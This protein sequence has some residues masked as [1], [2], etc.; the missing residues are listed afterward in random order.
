MR[1]Y[2]FQ[3]TMK[4]RG[5]GPQPT[6][7]ALPGQ[8]FEDGTPVDTELNVQAP[9]EAGTSKNGTRLE[10]PDGTY[11]C[12]TLLEEVTTS[13]GK[14]YY[15]VYGE[16]EGPGKKDPDFHPVSDDNKFKY[17]KPEHRSDAMNLAFVQFLTF[18]LQDNGTPAPSAASAKPGKRMRPADSGGKA[19]PMSG[20]WAPQ[21]DDQIDIEANL[22][23]IWM[24]RLLNEMGVRNM[25]KRP[26]TDPA[27][28]DRIR[29]LYASGESINTI[30]SRQRVMQIY[31][32][33]KMD[34]SG[35]QN[36]ASGP[37]EW[38]LDILVNEHRKGKECTALQRDT[39][40]PNELDDAAFLINTEMNTLL[41][42]TNSYTDPV[43]MDNLK[44]SLEAGWTLDDILDPAVLTQ[45]EDISTLADSLA[46]GAIPL[47]KNAATGGASFIDQLMVNKKNAC[48]KDKEGFHVDPL[49][50]KLLV[51]NL[52]RH[53]ATV[54][55][56]PT[57]S[58]KTELI[59][60]L[61]ERTGTP[62][63]IIPMGTITDP[64]EQLIGK[65]DLDPSTQGTKFDW[66]DFAL[67]IQRPGVILLDEINRC[68]KNGTNILFSVLDGTATLVASGAKS[69]DQ[70]NIKVN[71][72]CVF[73]ATANIGYEYT[74][75]SQL[76]IALR[77]R[78]MPIQLKYLDVKE[79]T[80]VLTVRTG[81][82][83]EDAR[84][85]SLIAA[86]IR[87]SQKNG[88]LEHGVST[89]ETLMCAELV[90]DGFE[91]EEALEICFLPNFEEGVTENDPNSE[92]GKVRAIIAS[93]FNNN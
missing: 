84:N 85:I 66:A 7:R 73:F 72:D 23:V 4:D 6:L 59:R 34:I 18:G 10:Y 26:K 19:I 36:I 60:M 29:E 32:E 3:T 1:Y 45:R 25:V 12:S 41:G 30:A 38:Y 27:V 68:P 42:T 78:F 75:T 28:M 40:N 57:G 43:V 52:N 55:T 47:P 2:F 31:K 13:T 62:L 5:N 35:L 54:M 33:Q 80:K 81:I 93:R 53:Q 89:R 79:E 83:E 71:P 44:K 64:V 90:R 39:T 77:N 69:T 56:G 48:P 46:S 20:A 9:K 76:D 92:Q 87:K 16:D 91:L 11:F 37:F 74:G 65:M 50:W 15:T 58:G 82:D 22:I 21:Y 14:T 88:T 49:T 70:R 86:N 17:V 8:T 61:C 63:T 67:A 24:R 51:R